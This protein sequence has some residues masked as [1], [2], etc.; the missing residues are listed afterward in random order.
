MSKKAAELASDAANNSLQE[1]D[2][3]ARHSSRS[4]NTNKFEN[5]KEEPIINVVDEIVKV[6][7]AGNDCNELQSLHEIEQNVGEHDLE[8][9]FHGSHSMANTEDPSL[10]ADLVRDL[11]SKLRKKERRIAK[12]KEELS[13]FHQLEEDSGTVDIGE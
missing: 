7:G 2:E 3:G 13:K 5:R 4:R 12:L 1:E 6:F 8:N 10:N 9:T 11:R